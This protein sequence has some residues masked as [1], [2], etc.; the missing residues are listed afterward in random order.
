[1][2]YQIEN[3]KLF[4]SYAHAHR[5]PNRDDLFANPNTKPEKLHDFELGLEKT[6]GNVSF[7]ANAYYMNY[8]NQ[9]VLSGEINMVGEFIKI[10]SG[11]SYRLGLELGTLAKVSEKLNVLGNIT[12]SQNKNVDF[13]IEENS[14]VTNLGNTD[15]SFSPNIIANA[16]I[17][18]K[19]IKN[20]QLNL[21]NQYIG[22]QYLDN[23]ETQ[24][25]QLND[26]FLTDFNAQY[27]FKIAK[28]EVSLQFLLNN[29]FDKKYVNNGFVYDGPYYYAQA[30]RNFMIGLSFKI[31]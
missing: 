29:I 26:Y 3:G 19:P 16:I 10:N 20:L 7:T 1:V 23:T 24:S 22:K 13:K 21:N 12:L 28:Q 2:N 17:Q 5:E 25:L 30:G 27:E 4:F 6:F 18:Y 9:L 31:K 8:V 15:I 14:T 11:K